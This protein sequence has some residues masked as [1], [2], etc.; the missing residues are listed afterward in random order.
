MTTLIHQKNVFW[1]IQ[2][3]LNFFKVNQLVSV[4]SFPDF[5]HSSI[6]SVNGVPTQGNAKRQKDDNNP[7]ADEAS[8]SSDSESSGSGDGDVEKAEPPKAKAPPK[9]H[10]GHKKSSRVAKGQ[11]QP[12][13]EEEH[14]CMWPIAKVL[15]AD[16]KFFYH[17][18]GDI[19]LQKEREVQSREDTEHCKRYLYLIFMFLFICYEN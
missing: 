8:D 4:I 13:E 17:N 9:T 19:E 7:V 12:E 6:L 15:L 3:L 1:R 5:C 16:S 11:K 14:M 2:F 10:Q 18:V